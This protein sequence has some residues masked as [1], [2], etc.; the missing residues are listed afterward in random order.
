MCWFVV[1]LCLV[2][3]QQIKLINILPELMFASLCSFVKSRYFFLGEN[4]TVFLCFQDAGKAKETL[5]VAWIPSC[6]D[7]WH[8]PSC[9]TWL[10]PALRHSNSSGPPVGGGRGACWV[11]ENM[12]GP[13]MSGRRRKR[14][15]I[16]LREK[17]KQKE[18]NL[19]HLC[20]TTPNQM[21]GLLEGKEKY[22][23]ALGRITQ[24][25]LAG[26]VPSLPV[27]LFWFQVGG[28]GSH[29]RHSLSTRGC[30]DD[31]TWVDVMWTARHNPHTRTWKPPLNP[32]S[33]GGVAYTSPSSLCNSC[34]AIFC[35]QVCVYT[36]T[37]DQSISQNNLEI[38]VCLQNPGGTD[39][40]LGSGFLLKWCIVVE[41]DCCRSSEDPIGY[42]ELVRTLASPRLESVPKTR[43][44]GRREL[45]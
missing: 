40:I 39:H 10:K 33:Q 37:G 41:K 15:L 26:K 43:R 42:R 31:S 25:D 6:L 35:L 1:C 34:A 19:N 29:C 5:V 8:Q 18:K 44:V 12:L 23:L 17:K 22:G 13:I 30:R 4:L 20:L 28:S 36:A 7:P 21:L 32:K 24:N 16:S 2:A 38:L 14:C 11:H 27:S 3:I 45:R 9:A